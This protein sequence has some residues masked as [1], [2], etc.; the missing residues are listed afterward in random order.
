MSQPK[1]TEEHKPDTK[2]RPPQKPILNVPH[3]FIKKKVII[4]TIQPDAVQQWAKE[5]SD[6]LLKTEEQVVPRKEFLAS[7]SDMKT[8][9]RNGSA[10]VEQ[11]A[12]ELEEM[13]LR[14]VKASEAIM[15]RA[16]SLYSKD[17]QPP[18]DYTF[19]YSVDI[20]K[21][22]KKL[23]PEDE[24]DL[25][26]TCRSLRRVPVARSEH[27]DGDISLDTS[28]V[29]FSEEIFNC[30]PEVVKH[31]YW[32]EALLSTFKEN[33]AQDASMDF[34]YFCSAKG[35]LRTYPATSW[36]SMFKLQLEDVGDVYDCRLRPWY[37]SASG[38]PRDVLILLDATGSMDNSSN[39][40]I[41]EQFTLAMLN[42]LTDDDQVNVLRFNKTVKSPIR[43]FDYK[44][45][46]ANHVNSAAMMSALKDLKMYNLTDM[47]YVLNYSVRMLQ[48]QR[49]TP[50][51][52]P[53]CQ[54]AIV[55][56]T[57]SMEHNFTDKMRLLDPSGRIRLFVMWLHD[58]YGL[59]DNT[60]QLGQSV[61]CDRDGHFAELVTTAD[62]TEQV[63][64]V[65][66]VLER[67][68]V[69][70]RSRRLRVYSDVYA[71]LEDPRRSE[72]YWRQKENAE[73]VYRYNELRKNK[74]KLLNDTYK[75]HMHQ[76]SLD[77]QGFY[78]EGIDRNY[79]LQI[80][81]SVPV[82]ESTTVE[83]ITIQLFEED[84]RNATRTY[85]VN[86]LLGVAG[87]DIPIDH[88]K[89]ILPYYQLGAGGSLFLIDHRGNIVLHDNMKP[90]FD[91]DILKPGYR[92]VDFMDLE[93]PDIPH[94][95]RDYPQDW[96][97]FRK[98]LVISQPKG[99][100]VMNGK[101]VYEYGMR[102]SMEP[103]EYH[104]RRV[105][106]HYTAV[107][108]LPPYGRK[109]AVP[110]S[111]FTQQ[112]A[113]A[114]LKTL[115][116]SDF[117]V[118]PDW[119]YCR[120]VEPYFDSQDSEVLH[121]IRR[122]SDEPNFAMKKLKHVYSNIPPAL[123]DKTYQCNEQLMARL[124]KEAV[125][126]SEW[127]DEHQDFDCMGCVL[128]AV[129]AFYAGESGLTRWRQYRTPSAHAPAPGGAEWS[130]GPDEPWYRHAVAAAPHLTVHAPV[131]PARRMRNT[132]ITPPPL[133]AKDEWLTAAR[134]LTNPDKS[135]VGV[136]GY[137]FHPQHLADLLDAVTNNTC[138]LEEPDCKPSC[139]G[140][141]WSCVLIDEGG[142][143]VAGVG[144]GEE[145]EGGAARVHLSTAHPAAMAA[146]LGARVY[147][148]N[149]LHDYQAV[150]F[151]Y[152]D[153]SAASMV[154]PSLL[155]SLWR[156]VYLIIKLTQELVTL[157]AI[158]SK[159]TLV[160]GDTQKEKDKRRNRVRRD[161]ER[162]KYERL[163]DDR[164]LVNR[165]RFAACDRSR[166]L[167]ELNRTAEAIERL[168]RAPM[169]CS[170]P[171]VGAPVP[172]T[173][174]VLLAVYTRCPRRHKPVPAPLHNPPVN[175]TKLL[176]KKK[177][178]WGD[179][180]PASE[181]ACWRNAD[182]LPGRMPHVQCY[183]H[184]YTQEEGYRQ[185]GPWIPDPE[186]EENC[187]ASLPLLFPVKLFVLL[188]FFMTQIIYNT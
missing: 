51:R 188:I 100:R 66:R 22:K 126:T 18:D 28:S 112:L 6:V 153:T 19:D 187:A 16:E 113:E 64:R 117:S 116:R 135:I 161:F 62:V 166:P 137:H 24:W 121:F 183:Q 1:K 159:G 10:I 32:S 55:L 147:S 69:A 58:R 34:Q 47:E 70:Q 139:D 105:V 174:L 2:P 94:E 86:R 154:L 56:V 26:E 165:T 41:A 99:S 14:R 130:R 73:Q 54:Q 138:D 175:V 143:V 68:L 52:P 80:S 127:A 131:T 61:S 129:T 145:V 48:R 157:L 90:V 74:A 185:C 79:R 162:E 13:L 42:A 39:Q 87:V 122:R 63:M 88:L 128:G 20:D 5:I 96:K 182:P 180:S 15:K 104:W 102:A 67:P 21:L 12:N 75:H 178:N 169:L 53:S 83:N 108:V 77:Q 164:V 92:T 29:H 142:W 97:E 101:N 152:V 148:L 95:P 31:L 158:L 160:Y 114:A 71:H 179:M 103:R 89:L 50:E 65:L 60:L 184:N 23:S 115:S 30:A 82:F 109:H 132:A 111:S 123:L 4:K 84:P 9:V 134:A 125:A 119:L 85:P 78:Y 151:P 167:Y 173:N 140:K 163:Y 17:I 146:L 33:Y 98:S 171:L 46:P 7:F 11:M 150:C 36:S 181:L 170:W 8:A 118:H 25:P 37:V 43:C 136:A 133:G 149:W 106:D 107:V 124:C 144:T 172:H 72:Y 27:F 176:A 168:S 156:S 44:L 155:K 110:E 91:G 3:V 93:Q 81:V 177:M 120:H 57:D 59:R 76:Q 49:G 141:D 40:V 35:F 186:V 38:A 45:V